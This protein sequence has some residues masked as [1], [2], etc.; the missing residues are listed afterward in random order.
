MVIFYKTSSSV[1]LGFG[2]IAHSQ[3]LTVSLTSKRFY[4]FHNVPAS[5]VE[6]FSK[7][8]SSGKFFFQNIRNKYEFTEF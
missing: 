5:V 2:Y 7:A 8:E 3:K 6:E 1:I 4:I